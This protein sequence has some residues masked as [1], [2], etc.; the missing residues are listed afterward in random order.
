MVKSVVQNDTRV[1]LCQTVNLLDEVANITQKGST[2]LPQTTVVY[3][4]NSDIFLNQHKRPKYSY[5]YVFRALVTNKSSS[6]TD[7]YI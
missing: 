7:E 5:Y 4:I 2:Y 1:Y 6:C 3:L